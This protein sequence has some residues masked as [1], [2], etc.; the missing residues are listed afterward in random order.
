MKIYAI[1]T[2]SFFAFSVQIM[3]ASAP[4]E[5]ACILSQCAKSKGLSI[6]LPSRLKCVE[7]SPYKP[8]HPEQRI[9]LLFPWT[10][11]IPALTNPPVLKRSWTPLPIIPVF[12]SPLALIGSC[13]QPTHTLTSPSSARRSFAAA[14]TASIL[15]SP[16]VLT[17]GEQKTTITLTAPPTPKRA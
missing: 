12:A 7:K 16:L 4:Q 9:P 10:Q 17:R 2:L 8:R 11:E 5:Q 15:T 1:L 14:P 3:Q 13:A 6:I